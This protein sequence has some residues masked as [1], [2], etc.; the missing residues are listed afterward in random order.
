[1]YKLSGFLALRKLGVVGFIQQ[2]VCK[3]QKNSECFF[4]YL[5]LMINS[6][7]GLTPNIF[8]DIDASSI[9]WQ[10]HADFVIERVL[11]RG[12]FEDWIAIKNFYGIE[13]IK[14]TVLFTRY[15]DKKTLGF[16]SIIF[17]IPKEQFRCHTYRQLNRELWDY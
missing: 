11:M 15:L 13:K 1:M 10:Q 17:N 5:C 4:S 6:T 8:W 16:C 3:C 12:T 9:D 2:E 14:N 7:I